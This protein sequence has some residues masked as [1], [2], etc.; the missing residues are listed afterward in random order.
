M[1]VALFFPN[2]EGMR[3]LKK[4]RLN[5][6]FINNFQTILVNLPS[7]WLIKKKT[8]PSEPGNE[9]AVLYEGLLLA[10]ILSIP[11]SYVPLSRVC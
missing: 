8:F 10:L 4:R 5:L 1:K 6:K 7:R 11:G 9:I 2:I 3:E